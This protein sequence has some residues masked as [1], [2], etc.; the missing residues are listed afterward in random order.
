MGLTQHGQPVHHD[1]DFFCH[2]KKPQVSQ[3]NRQLNFDS[4]KIKIVT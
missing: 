3:L 4:I 1:S 2:S